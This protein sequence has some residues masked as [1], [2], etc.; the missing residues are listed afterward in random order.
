VLQTKERRFTNRRL[1]PTSHGGG[2]ES[3]P[4]ESARLFYRR[5]ANRRELSLELLL[6]FLQSLKAELPPMQLD[7]ELIDIT[8]YLRAL[9]FVLF[10]LMLK[11]RN[12]D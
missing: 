9:R 10:E 4:L 5:T 11:L 12:L 6:A 1:F 3:A 8:R 2:L 7:T